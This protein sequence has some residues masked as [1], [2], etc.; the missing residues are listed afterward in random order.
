MEFVVEAKDS[1]I[2][3]WPLHPSEKETKDLAPVR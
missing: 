2:L 1:K 3:F